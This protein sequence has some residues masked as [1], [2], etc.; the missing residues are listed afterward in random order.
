MKRPLPDTEVRLPAANVRVSVVGR[1]SVVPVIGSLGAVPVPSQPSVID[2][3]GALSV[4]PWSIVE[5]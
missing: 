1:V 4:P 2:P 5:A 3:I